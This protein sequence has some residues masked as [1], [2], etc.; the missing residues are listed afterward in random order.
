MLSVQTPNDSATSN[1]NLTLNALQFF[2]IFFPSTFVPL[3]D[4]ILSNTHTSVP[5]SMIAIT[6]LTAAILTLVMSSKR[7]GGGCFYPA[8]YST[9]LFA[10]T[11]TSLNNGSMSDVLGIGILVGVIQLALTPLLSPLRNIFSK[12]LAGLISILIGI[13]IAQIGIIAMISPNQLAPIL[14][15]RTLGHHSQF[16]STQT[17]IGLISLATMLYFRLHHQDKHKSLCLLYACLVGWALTWLFG[18]PNPAITHLIKTSPWISN[19]LHFHWQKPTFHL[20]HLSTYLITAIIVFL[21]TTAFIVLTHR[22]DPETEPLKPKQH[23]SYKG[24]IVASIGLIVSSLLGAPQSPNTAA[25]GGQLTSGT[26]SN[27]LAWLYAA[28][29]LLVAISPKTLV[30]FLSVPA[31][32]RGATLLMIGGLMFIYGLASTQIESARRFHAISFTL[33]LL[34]AT[35]MIITTTNNSTHLSSLNNITNPVFAIAIFIYIPLIIGDTIF[36][37]LKSIHD[38][39]V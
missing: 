28:L 2:I 35:G 10:L 37:K 34:I 31:T 11:V 25:Y 32:V 24:N 27:K 16:N 20:Y 18:S 38:K 17:L 15:H 13:W 29:L 5:F 8:C 1:I 33:S 21:Q 22:E 7:I 19:P 3:L 30:A 39:K 9:P 6:C 36:Q 26:F 23:Y 12:R 14:Y 4:A